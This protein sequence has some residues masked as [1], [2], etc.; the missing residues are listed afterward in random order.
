LARIGQ[1]LNFVQ[2]FQAKSAVQSDRRDVIDDVIDQVYFQINSKVARNLDAK[3]GANRTLPEF[4]MIFPS[5]K[6]HPKRPL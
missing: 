3:F 4:S 5:C 2:N 6:G 1:F